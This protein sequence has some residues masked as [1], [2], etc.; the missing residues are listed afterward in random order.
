MKMHGRQPTTRDSHRRSR[1]AV[2]LLGMV[3]ALAFL[4]PLACL[5]HCMTHDHLA[6]PAP[7]ARS[8]FLCHVPVTDDQ[9]AP[10]HSTSAMSSAASSLPRATHE[11]IVALPLLAIVAG[12]IWR[13]IIARG[14]KPTQAYPLIPPP[15][16]K[17]LLATA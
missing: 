5:I 9:L 1:E 3:V 8:P 16:P 6:T 11:A 13:L 7:I 10:P 4:N 2:A 15:P 14:N 12:T 17:S